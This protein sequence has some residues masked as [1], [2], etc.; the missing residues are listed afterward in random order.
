MNSTIFTNTFSA[1]NVLEAFLAGTHDSFLIVDN[2]FSVIAFNEGYKKFHLNF[3]NDVVAKHINYFALT[4]ANTNLKVLH[5]S[6]VAIQKNMDV[7]KFTHPLTSTQ[8]SKNYWF[9]FEL[10]PLYNDDNEAVGFGIGI[11]DTTQKNTSLE[12]I[13]K[14]EELFKALVINSTDTFQLTNEELKVSY[15]SNS[16][17][18]ILG[19][20]TEEI[21]DNHFFNFIHPDDK[22]IISTW[23]YWLLHHPGIVKSVEVRIKNKKDNWIYIE[24]NGNNLLHVDKIQSIVMNYRDIQA[25]KVVDNALAIAEQRMSLLLNNTKESFIIVNSRLRVVTYNRAAQEHSPFFFSQELQSGISLLDLVKEFDVEDIINMFEKVFEGEE[26]ERETSFVD[27]TNKLHVYNHRFR[28]LYSDDD[29]VGVFITSTDITEKKKAEQKLIASEE[30]NRAIIQES[31]DVMLISDLQGVVQETSPSL[32]KLL[33]YAAEEV[34]GKNFIDFIDVNYRESATTTFNAL[35]TKPDSEESIDTLML[36]KEGHKV[37]VV[38]K[39][40]NLF[41]NKHINSMIIM[42]RDFTARKEAEE[43]VSLSEQRFKGLV[44]SGADMISIIDENGVVKYSSPTVFNVLGN[45]PITDIGKNVI[46]FIHPQD[47]DWI[48]SEFKKMLSSGVKQSHL[49]PYRFPNSKGEYKWLET[50]VTN[51]NDDPAIKGIVINSRDVTETKRL[52][53]EQKALTEE[54]IKN[55]QDLQQFSFITSHNLRAPVANL[56]SLLSLFDKE[57]LEEPFNKVLLEKFEEATGQMNSTLN[58]LLEVLVLKTNTNI[59]LEELSLLSISQQVLNNL[60]NILQQ[61]EVTVITNFSAVDHVYIN[62]LHLE[63]I[64][65][66]LI[67]NAIKYSSTERKPVINIDSMLENEWIIVKFSDN[68]IGIDLERYKDRIFGMYQRF[69]ASKEGKGLGLYMIKAQIMAMGG[70]IEVE[71]EVNSGTTFKVYL[72]NNGKI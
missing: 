10:H 42:L 20:E 39:G 47:K 21:I 68:G 72:K 53:E 8:E 31:F 61:N 65:Q 1:Q 41:H 7:L 54:L 62:K 70:K 57:N 3:F 28:P 6:L 43:V 64:F 16:V 51:L 25:K 55:N 19:Y 18:N 24:I 49:G 32:I 63:S 9:D 71:S 45:D 11:F 38:L 60:D 69:N 5:Q 14:S 4:K 12:A 46:S 17:K 52:N 66:N 48:I 59:T 40:K 44:Q 35:I 67:S 2:N 30:R 33:G 26:P 15:V 13:K 23:L 27:P 50:V 58:D 36:H 22:V 29:I 34:V 37:W 56:I